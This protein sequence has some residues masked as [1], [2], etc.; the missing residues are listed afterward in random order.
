M[1]ETL[2]KIKL[3]F[4]LFILEEGRPV[5]SLKINWNDLMSQ[6]D[7]VMRRKKCQ[8]YLLIRVRE[9]IGPT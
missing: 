7:K 1:D 5:N 4:Y 2:S 9:E 3:I 8:K 6:L